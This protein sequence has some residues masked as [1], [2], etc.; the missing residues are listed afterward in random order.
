MFLHRTKY[1]WALTPAE[2]INI[3]KVWHKYC[4]FVFHE[5]QNYYLKEETDS[6][7]D[8]ILGVIV[9]QL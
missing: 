5:V 8:K 2:S 4:I 3:Q 6:L 9:P 1:A 7:T